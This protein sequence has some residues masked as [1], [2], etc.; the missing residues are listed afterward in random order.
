[1]SHSNIV[2]KAHDKLT[3]LTTLFSI[4]FWL[5][6]MKSSMNQYYPKREGTSNV[7]DFNANIRTSLCMY[8][9]KMPHTIIWIALASNRS[10]H[11][12]MPNGYL[13]TRTIASSIRGGTVFLR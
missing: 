7:G 11:L 5:E 4:A 1:M 3:T 12:C 6:T 9:C 8:L 10:G 13:L 2:W